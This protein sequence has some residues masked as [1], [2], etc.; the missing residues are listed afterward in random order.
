[1]SY[2]EGCIES[3]DRANWDFH[4]RQK[5]WRAA[6]VA[7]AKWAAENWENPWVR[8]GDSIRKAPKVQPEDSEPF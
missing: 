2:P 8:L 6:K 5:A 1:M 7:D 3:E 4:R